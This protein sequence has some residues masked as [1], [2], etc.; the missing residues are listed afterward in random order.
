MKDKK[1]ISNLKGQK[2]KLLKKECNNEQEFFEIQNKLDEVELKLL[3][4]GGD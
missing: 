2:I 4:A 1:I 3:I